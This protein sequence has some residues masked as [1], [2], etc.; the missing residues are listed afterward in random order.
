MT[1]DAKTTAAVRARID[2]WA[3]ALRAKD[4]DGI[5]ASHAPDMLA[6]DCHSQ[7]EFQ[8]AE[9]YRRHLEGCMPDTQGPMLFEL[10]DLNIVAQDDVAF[11]HY[12]ALCGATGADGT[13]HRCWLRGT[14]C[15]RRTAGTWRIVHAHCSA[16]FDPQ[17]G[18][19]ML[20]LVPQRLEQSS[21]A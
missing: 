6:F 7:L 10:H 2:E 16:P 8:G 11:C 5:M 17:S 12:L 14:T 19:A 4:I 3:A 9:P 21:A 18:R 15:L 13:E 1:A 20:D